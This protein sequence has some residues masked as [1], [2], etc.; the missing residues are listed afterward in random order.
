[1][2]RSSRLRVALVPA[3][4]LALAAA[5]QSHAAQLMRGGYMASQTT[6]PAADTAPDGL[7]PSS[8]A[9][10]GADPGLTI[11]FTPRG[12]GSVLLD[13][14][15]LGGLDMPRLRLNFSG[16]PAESSRI[17]L[18]PG[19]PDP[20]PPPGSTVTDG[21][22]L[23]LGGALEWSSFSIGGSLSRTSLMGTETDMMG[24]SVGYGS[25]TTS[26]SFG[27]QP[28]SGAPNRDFWLLSTDL[29]ALPWLSLEG[30]FAVES[31]PEEEPSTVGRLGVR[32][33]F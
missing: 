7:A 15:G 24:A 19:T 22:T 30:A 17:G 28:R 12:G 10:S 23:A 27:E 26:L 1:M 25:L 20:N 3:V 4:A 8:F 9:L 31:A 2:R 29:L 13:D 21:G 11:D 6:T 18:L 33:H 14:L 32:L 5:P 16:A